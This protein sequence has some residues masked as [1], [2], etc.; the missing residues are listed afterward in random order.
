MSSRDISADLANHFGQDVTTLAICW[1]ITRKDG[2]VYAFTS[3]DEDLVIDGITYKSM[4]MSET[5]AFET[6]GDATV[7]NMEIDTFLDHD[8]VTQI[9]LETGLFDSADVE[10]CIVNYEDLGQGKLK[11]LKGEFGEVEIGDDIAKVELRSMAQKLNQKIGRKYTNQCDADLG[12]ARCGVDLSEYEETGTITH[13]VNRKQFGDTSRT[14]SE[15]YFRYGIITFTSGYN[16]GYSFEIKQFYTQD[17]IDCIQMNRSDKW[18]LASGNILGIY[19]IG[20]DIDVTWTAASGATT[21]SKYTVADIIFD[22][23]IG[24]VSYD[25]NAYD[26]DYMWSAGVEI[27]G[28]PFN[29]S[30]GDEETTTMKEGDT[31]EIVNSTNQNG[32]YEVSSVSY[33]DGTTT[34]NVTEKINIPRE[35]GGTYIYLDNSVY[36]YIIPTWSGLTASIP[37]SD[38]NM[39]ELWFETPFSV[40]AG[41]TYKIYPGCDKFKTTCI[42]KFDNVINF[43]GFDMIPGRDEAMKYPDAHF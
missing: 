3:C 5:T 18:I 32:E 36:G 11:V 2:E 42:N 40:R 25:G 24:E 41:D 8:D 12:D 1:K 33:S 17:I 22:P 4:N 38:T 28:D 14:E 16:N 27:T 29:L 43:R 39:F 13:V 26:I 30:D 31:F 6:T 9:D 21:T 37:F 35:A 10:V 15:E 7:S 23:I 20:D 19:N 34:I